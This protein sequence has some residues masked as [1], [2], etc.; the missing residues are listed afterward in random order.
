MYSD[1]RWKGQNHPGQN[2]PEKRYSD[3]TPGTKITNWERIC[4]EGF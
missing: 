1:I 2:L 4:A 3:K